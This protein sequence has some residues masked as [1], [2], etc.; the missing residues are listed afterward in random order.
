[1][2]V[3]KGQI[4]KTKQQ[5]EKTESMLQEERSAGSQLQ[6]MEEDYSNWIAD[7]RDVRFDESWKI[8]VVI[9]FLLPITLICLFFWVILT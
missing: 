8:I 2:E 5:L 1:V 9:A 7:P 4:T 3:L 6:E